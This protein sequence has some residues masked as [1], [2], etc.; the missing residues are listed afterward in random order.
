M[1]I[2][3]TNGFTLASNNETPSTY[4]TMD[5]EF[6]EDMSLVRGPHQIGFGADFIRSY[7]NGTSGLNASGPFTFNGQVTSGSSGVGLADFLLGKPS[8]L[9]QATTTLAYD[10][11]NYFG[12]Y[13]QDTWKLTPRFTVNYGVRWDPYL[14]LSTKYGWTP[15]FDPSLF[16]QNT[17][18][19]VFVNAPSGL[20]FPGDS[21]YP[22]RGVAEQR[23]DNLAPRVSVAW[24][25]QGD[26][27]TSVRAAYGRFFDLPAMNNY[28]GFG[29]TPPIGNTTTVNFPSSFANP[30]TGI[31]GGNPYPLAVSAN[32]PF[33]NFGTYENFLLNPKTTYSQQ[34]NVSIQRQLGQN[35]LL[36]ANY[37]G[38][39]IVHLWGGNQ[40]NPGVYIPGSCDQQCH[41]QPLFHDRE[42]QLS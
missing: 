39:A 15:H 34:W 30:W 7:L 31:P 6:A 32:S 24:D 1:R 38:T 2:T 12:L 16:P 11:M 13:V 29:S 3:V 14:P 41:H 17:H 21:G 9:T 42:C 33:I 23:W 8:A 19:T 37:V 5:F 35:W 36:A 25:V 4:N 22:G 26:G 27:K 28:V 10:R 18:S 20:Q 40:A